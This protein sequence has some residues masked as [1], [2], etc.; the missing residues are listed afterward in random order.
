MQ[1]WYRNSFLYTVTSKS[2]IAQNSD[3]SIDV[4]HSVLIRT[5]RAELRLDSSIDVNSSASSCRPGAKLRLQLV[6][7]ISMADY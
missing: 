5:R 4:T 2:S 7:S 3:S 1:S 6:Q